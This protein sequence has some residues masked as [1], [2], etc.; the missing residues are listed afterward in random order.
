M[1]HNLATTQFPQKCPRTSIT[2][3]TPSI[4]E[5]KGTRPLPRRE[6]ARMRVRVKSPPPAFTLP[7]LRFG[8]EPGDPTPIY[9]GG[10]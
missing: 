5:W 7:N 6:R 8:R 9:R 3:V 10:V 2:N 1:E 4:V